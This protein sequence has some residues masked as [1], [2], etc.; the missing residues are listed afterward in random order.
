MNKEYYILA[1]NNNYS[2]DP[3]KIDDV[4]YKGEMYDLPEEI[5]EAVLRSVYEPLEILAV[6]GLFS[7]RDVITGEV[8]ES[9]T[10][11]DI[12][13]LSYF[14]AVLASRKDIIRI[15][16]KYESMSSQDISRYKDAINKIKEISINKFIEKEKLL[17]QEI[18]EEKKARDFL[19][20]F[21][22]WGA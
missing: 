14:K 9:S 2:K 5:E 11:G 19:I 13:G 22:Q 8:I 4:I 12:N 16:K 6:R 10:N 7:L 15:T 3:M 21:Q 17:Y 1:L 20:N 18:N